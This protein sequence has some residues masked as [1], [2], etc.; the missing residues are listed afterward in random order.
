[1]PSFEAANREMEE[2]MYGSVMRV[3]VKPGHLE[4]LMKA[5]NGGEGRSEDGMGSVF[6]FQ[7][8]SD[9]NELFMVAVAESEEAYRA[10]SERPEMHEQYLR[11]REHYVAEPEWHD[12]KVIFHRTNA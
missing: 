10:N 6:V 11:M 9:P 2:T 7:M 12:G 3:K 8:D 5:G 1:M 4:K